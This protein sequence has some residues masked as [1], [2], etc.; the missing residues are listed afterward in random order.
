[1]LYLK[2]FHG[3]KDPDQDM[4]DWGSDGP[5]FGPYHFIHT[6]YNSHLFLGKHRRESHE[7]WLH[8]D[9]IKYD[10][11]YYGDGSVFTEDIFKNEDPSRLQPFDSAKAPVPDKDS[12]MKTW[13]AEKP[14]KIIVTIRGGVCQEVK[15]NLSDGCWEYALVDYD[16][17][18]NLPDN[19]H[20]YRASE[21]QVVPILPVDLFHVAKK[22]ID[23]W[24]T[25]HLAESV[26]ELDRVISD[27]EENPLPS[28]IK[29]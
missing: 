28:E 19:Y 21:M 17:E 9:V 13:L 18:P 1:M 16:N 24:E 7:L 2:L 5:I 10:G 8:G 4:D 23:H 6:V 22:V 20:P 11:V 14:V 27:I 26:R 25:G 29:E 3:R 15:T 12:V